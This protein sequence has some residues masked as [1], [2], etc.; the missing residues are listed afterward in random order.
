MKYR[1]IAQ[2][3]LAELLRKERMIH[4][5]IPFLE[6]YSVGEVAEEYK[7]NFSKEDYEFIKNTSDEEIT[8]IFPV[9]E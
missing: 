6:N 2:D 9:N 4:T 1:I 3:R 8:N 7:G 5:I